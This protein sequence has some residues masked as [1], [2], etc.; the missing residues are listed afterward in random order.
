M[1]VLSSYL[2][3]FIAVVAV[4]VSRKSWNNRLLRMYGRGLDMTN[5]LSY[6]ILPFI[7]WLGWLC[8]TFPTSLSIWVCVLSSLTCTCIYP[9][10]VTPKCSGKIFGTW[11]ALM[12]EG[13]LQYGNRNGLS[14]GSKHVWTN[15]RSD[16]AIYPCLLL[17]WGSLEGCVR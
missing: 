16:V 12:G 13:G 2:Q 1:Q 11:Y 7:N 9:R 15:C 14:V 3:H 6:S 4:E 10:T 8:L 5:E 17:Q